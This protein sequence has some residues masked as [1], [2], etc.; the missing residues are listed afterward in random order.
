VGLDYDEPSEGVDFWRVPGGASSSSPSAFRAAAAELL[1]VRRPE[2]VISNGVNCPPGDVLWVHSVHRSWVES[3]SSVRVRGL[4]VPAAVRRLVPRHRELLRLERE[5]FTQHRP[6]AVLCT[7][8]REKDDLARL[9]GVDR[10][11]MHVVP[12]GF[13]GR[14]FDV[15]TRAATR[16]AARIE[17]GLEDGDVC[18]LFVANELHR[19][20]FSVLLQAVALAS[21][22]RLRID[23]VGRVSPVAFQ[24]QIEHLGLTRR[25]RWHGPTSQ[26]ERWMAAGDLLVLPTQYEP[27]GLVV[28]EA[29]AMGL[30]VITT[31]LAG[32]APAVSP[33]TGLLQQDPHDSHELAGLLLAAL[34][35]GLLEQWSAAAPSAAASYEWSAI[36][37]SVEGLIFGAA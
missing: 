18:L 13:D 24:G 3:G 10:E 5:Y 7:S 2:V 12:N 14:R 32:A 4:P 36:L 9:Y 11:L 29:L 6:R 20:G 16:P 26:V 35:P 30:P 27:F 23:V 28:V 25:V 17:L 1:A 19:K 34:T 22:P 37:E 33:G 15:R 8:P 21:D 31:A